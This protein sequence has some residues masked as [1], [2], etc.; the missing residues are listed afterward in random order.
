LHKN[1]QTGGF[2]AC[3]FVAFCERT[4]KPD[5]CGF[6]GITAKYPSFANVTLGVLFGVYTD[7]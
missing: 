3:F 5:L 7:A 6:F 2:E 1:I 4:Y